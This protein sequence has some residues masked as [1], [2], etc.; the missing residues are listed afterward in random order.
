M[1]LKDIEIDRRRLIAG[2]LIIGLAALGAGAGTMAWF[3]D[4]EQS[5]DN[6]IVAG[7]LDLSNPAN[8]KMNIGN[9]AP[10]DR[11]PATA[12]TTVS[13]QTTYQQGN[14]IGPIMVNLSVDTS[15]PANEPGEPPHS[16]N[17]SADQFAKEMLVETA[18]LNV[19]NSFHQDLLTTNPSITTLRDLSGTTLNDTFGDVN[20][21]STVSLDLALRFNSSAGNNYQADGV[22]MTVTFV[23]AQHR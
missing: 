18:D 23:G 7:E 11:V 3:S 1:A 4:V 13:F 15:H 22:N 20:P 19:N 10:D 6:K 12:G 14:A 8:A 21:G 16:S 2:I 17:V 9:L 5:T